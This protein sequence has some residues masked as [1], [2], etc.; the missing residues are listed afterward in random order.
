MKNYF[1]SIL[2]SSKA[3]GSNLGI[4]LITI[5]SNNI[6]PGSIKMARLGMDLKISNSWF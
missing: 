1:S 2:L 6:P 3:E 4:N 5:G